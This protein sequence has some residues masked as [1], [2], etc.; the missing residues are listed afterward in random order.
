[1]TKE[2][3]QKYIHEKSI[4][5]DA[6]KGSNTFSVG[7][8]VRILLPRPKIGKIR[9]NY[10]TVSY[11][12]MQVKGRS[13]IIQAKD[14][15]VDTVP[16]IQLTRCHVQTYPQAQTIKKDKRAFVEYV[17]DYDK[18]NAGKFASYAV[19]YENEEK[20]SPNRIS[21]KDLREGNPTSLS[22][23]EKLYWIKTCPEFPKGVP[24]E[25]LALIPDYVKKA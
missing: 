22:R 15:S 5:A 16:G 3:E 23:E 6:V 12:I 7:E 11:K 14:G 4:I 20:V 9:N 21:V 10:S 18:G 17:T 24:P 25:I 19:K 13:Y 2:Q 1:M 8:F